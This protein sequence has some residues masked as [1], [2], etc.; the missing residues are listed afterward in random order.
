MLAKIAGLIVFG[1]GLASAQKLISIGGNGQIVFEYFPATTPLT[2]QALDAA[3]KP[4][5]NLPIT[6]SITPTLGTLVSSM[7]ATDA[8]GKATTLVVGSSPPQSTSFQQG[9]IVASSTL[10]NV[11]FF[12][13]TVP[14]RLPNGSLATPPQVTLLKPG[15]ANNRTVT[16]TA[17]QVLT[18]AIVV[19]VNGGGFVPGAPIPNVGVRLTTNDIKLLPAA[20]CNTPDGIVLTD[21]TG[22]ANCDVKFSSQIGTEQVIAQIGDFNTTPPILLTSTIGTACTYV[23]SE[24]NHLFGPAGGNASVSITTQTGCPWSASSNSG[25]VTFVSGGSGAGS[26]VLLYNVAANTGDARTATITLG[27]VLY[28]VQ[29]NSAALT[30]VSNGT[31]ASGAIG[32]SYSTTLTATGGTQPYTWSFAGS[33]PPGFTLST[34]GGTISGVT[35]A[36]GTYNFTL[37]VTDAVGTKATQPASINISATSTPSLTI[38]NTSFPVGTVGTIYQVALL[39]SGGCVTPFSKSPVFVLASGVLPDGLAVKQISD[40][41]YAVA[42]TPTTAGAS[43][44]TLK[45]TDACG[46]VASRSYSIAMQAAGVTSATISVAPASLSFTVQLGSSLPPAA[47]SL[48]ITA[49]SPGLSYTAIATTGSGGTWL[50]FPAGSGGNVPA[51]LQVGVAAFDQLVPGVYNGAIT[52]TS[53]ATNG[54]VNVPVTMTVLPAPSALVASPASVSFAVTPQSGVAA[55]QKTVQ[56]TATTTALKFVVSTSG[57]P[58]LSTNA[59]SGTTPAALNIIVNPAGLGIGAYSGTVTL[60]P[61][62]GTTVQTIAVSMTVSSPPTMTVNPT[63]LLFSVQQGSSLNPQT[64]NVGSTGDPLSFS[65]IANVAWLFVNNAASLQAKTPAPLSI[66]VN[67][68]G[69]AGGT[70]NG[71]ITVSQTDAVAVPFLVAVTLTVP[72]PPVPTVAAIT[73][74][75]SFARGPISPGEIVTV[76]GTNFGPQVLASLSLNSSGLVDTV[77]SN[78]RVLFDG[79]PAPM[80][81]ASSGQLSAVVPYTVRGR[82]STSVQ[83]E[84]LGVRSSGLVLPV[85]SAAPG[86]FTLDALGQ[87]AILNQDFTV[88]GVNNPAE[89]GSI[90]SIFAT[91]EGDT[92]PPGIDG[93]LAALPFPNPLLSVSVLIGGLPAD[94]YYAGGAPGA[95]SGL[96]QVNA[97]VPDGVTRGMPALV[98]IRIGD[99]TTQSGVTLAVKP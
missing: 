94:L 87:G 31:L 20:S 55:T 74:A 38:A 84:Y 89:P 5:A 92:N 18:G 97:K 65:A 34:A 83:V 78:T 24:T 98:Q 42:G 64:L 79:V 28:T 23:L 72:G 8:N 67:P 96:L 11:S 70:Y 14:S 61:I 9:N 82:N 73:N 57:N 88:N 43:N 77:I 27:G 76:F 91:G 10:G 90:V 51:S 40:S 69:L 6:W 21:A 85:S 86:I 15:T 17:G 37:T 52:I 35:S 44:F 63:S 36:A 3:G 19:Q 48:S 49:S 25:W 13:T 33:L 62:G 30:L 56:I 1:C 22:V 50:V 26:G 54:P 2:V 47:Q 29:Q 41:T 7:A 16:G 45:A 71:T 39:T 68:T 59:V 32:Q 95:I 4:V 60:T 46:N 53:Q 93:K 58:W 66:S 99:A 80:L 75:A 12:F 81:Y